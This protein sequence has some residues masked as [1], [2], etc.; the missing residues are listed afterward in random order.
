MQRLFNQRISF[1]MLFHKHYKTRKGHSEHFCKCPRVHCI[2]FSREH[3]RLVFF[4]FLDSSDLRF[5]LCTFSID[6]SLLFFFVKVVCS[7]VL[8]FVV[9]LIVNHAVGLL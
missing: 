1:M 8:L 4:N 3:A 9:K 5:A 7:V 6:F 2:S